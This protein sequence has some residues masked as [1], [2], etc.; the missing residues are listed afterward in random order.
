MLVG[1]QNPFHASFGVSPPL[2]VGRD[3]LLEDFVEALEDGPGSAGR[4]TLYTGA[5]GTGKTVMLNAVED[6]AR[7]RGWLIVSETATGG[8]VSRMTQ[9]HL[10]RLLRDFDPKAVQRR[11]SGVSAPLNIGALTWNTIEAHV[12]QAGLRNQLEMLTDLLAENRSG[13]LITLDEIHHNQ[14][15][16]LREL[17]TVVQH[18]FRENRELAFAGAGLVASVSDIVNDD[19]LT[20]LRRAERHTLGPVAR[21]DVQRAFRE[22]IQAAGRSI[23]EEA[24][25]IMVDGARGY[26]FMLQLVG[27]QTW[28][29]N[30]DAAEITV[31]D[32]THGVARAR[33]RLGALIHEP[34][35]SAASDIGKSFLLAMAQDDGPSKMADIQQRLG[36]DGNYA[37]Q[38]RL[39]LIAAELIYPTRRGYVDFALPYLREYLRQHSATE[40]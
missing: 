6:R 8:F 4:A 29:L 25:Q 24:L 23:G 36:V 31:D 10:P 40:V 35:L 16:E 15:E 39:R 3:E 34:A 13:V 19:V 2:L 5:R 11:M 22:P 1:M 30:P 17:A 14:I 28:R 21:A 32:A 33:L 9:Q 27:A 7:E 12:V 26:P 38:Y 18:A 20:F 37:S